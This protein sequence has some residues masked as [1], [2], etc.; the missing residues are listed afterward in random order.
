MF[1]INIFRAAI[2]SANVYGLLFGFTN[3]ISFY[4]NAAAYVLGAY[5][6][7]ENKFGLT[8]EKVMI[9]F[10]CIVFGAQSIGQTSSMMP[11]YAKAK[12]SAVKMF[13]LFDRKPKINNWE[14][15]SKKKVPDEQFDST[16]VFNS[17]EFK[18]PSRPDAPVLQNLSLIVK[19]GQRV[20]LV[21]SSGCGKST[22]TQLLERFYDPD[23]GEV[24]ISNLDAKTVDLHWLRS[25]IGI[26]SQEPILFDATIEENIAYGDNSRQVSL[27]EVIESAKQANIHD[28]I[29]SL[30]NGYETNVGS[31]GT[32]LSGGQKQRIAIARALVK[33]PKILLL[34]CLF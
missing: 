20:A 33:S 14:S 16:I 23:S 5:L 25:K 13:N 22:I 10:S 32:Q 6:I 27:D 7:E 2:R 1:K 12:A 19:R 9:V 26:V 17:L 24:R 15:E 31:K 34:V 30:P 11:D 8:F 21:G 18:Y 28:F 3:S 4:A 29:T